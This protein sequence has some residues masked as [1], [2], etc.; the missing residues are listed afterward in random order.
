MTSRRH[1]DTLVSASV[2]YRCVSFS[3]PFPPLIDW[4]PTSVLRDHARYK[5]D[6]PTRRCSCL[7]SP[8]PFSLPGGLTPA[9]VPGSQTNHEADSKDL[10]NLPK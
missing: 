5:Y 9:L 7:S 2:R 6:P 4:S 10:Q 1:A 8:P 3:P